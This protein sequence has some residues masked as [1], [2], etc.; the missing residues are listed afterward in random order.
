V[1][2]G[3][4]TFALISS[5]LLIAAV[6]AVLPKSAE[7]KQR[8]RA[9][10]ARLY[11]IKTFARGPWDVVV[12]GDSRVL[13][14]VS[15][16]AMESVL[17]GCR[18]FNFAYNSGSL[19]PEMY[20]SAERRLAPGPRQRAIVLGVTHLTLLARH[21]RNEQYHEILREPL[22]E[23]FVLMHLPGLARFCQPI[24]PIDLARLAV[25]VKPHTVYDQEFT[26]DGWIGTL[27]QPVNEN[28]AI[29]IYERELQ[30]TS[31]D[32]QLVQDLLAQT[33]AWTR[34]GIRV[35]GFRPPAPRAVSEIENRLTGFDAAAL[36]REFTRAGGIWLDFDG[37]AYATYDGSHLRRDQAVAFSQDLARAMRPYLE[38]SA[39]PAPVPAG[40]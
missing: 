8:D 22:D 7:P 24:L 3:R 4:V 12:M 36:A 23:R 1:A 25:Q 39:G 26:D 13:R 2:G 6:G 40:N 17:P 35:F 30:G 29:P 16:T 28:E 27:R 19:N 21:D 34:D 10:E 15:P 14:G 9:R 31:I 18:V 37:T 5:A 20:R 11:A 32:P 33:R 38:G